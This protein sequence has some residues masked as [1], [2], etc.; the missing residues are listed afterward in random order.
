MVIRIKH[1]SNEIR[2]LAYK[3][4]Q[5]VLSQGLDINKGSEML[6]L[7]RRVQA[8]VLPEDR[9][10]TVK[11]MQAIDRVM[12]ELTIQL[13]V[14]ADERAQKQAE[15]EPELEPENPKQ[16]TIED[17]LTNPNLETSMDLLFEVMAMGMAQRFV[18]HLKNALNEVSD[19]ELGKW[20]G[21]NRTKEI[22]RPRIL[23][24]GVRNNAHK[25]LTEEFSKS[26]DLRFIDNDNYI[27]T[28]VRDKAKHVD[29]II[30]MTDH[31]SHNLEAILNKHENYIRQPGTLDSL[32]KLLLS[33]A[34]DANS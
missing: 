25:M 18:K 10:R 29:A 16:Q 34:V 2:L 30:G 3:M 21:I 17:I 1:T 24:A 23:I 14:V 20:L 19:Q 26:L 27:M 6:S 12:A 13:R 8:E 32:R 4:A 31:M 11:T 7:F 9:Q 28:S 33:Y 15:P 5:S 22:R